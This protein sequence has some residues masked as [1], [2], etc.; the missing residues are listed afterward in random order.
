M[1]LQRK[2]LLVDHVDEYAYVLDNE[3]DGGQR[4]RS[5]LSTTTSLPPRMVSIN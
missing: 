2:I 5:Y 4:V 3:T 1:L